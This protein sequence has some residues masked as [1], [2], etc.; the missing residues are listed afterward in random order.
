MDT[1]LLK[2][3]DASSHVFSNYS[4]KMFACLCSIFSNMC[5][6]GW[7]LICECGISWSCLL[8]FYHKVHNKTTDT[9]GLDQTLSQ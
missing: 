4:S 6:M 8:V 5:A 1:P 2:Q 3:N 9:I 7:S